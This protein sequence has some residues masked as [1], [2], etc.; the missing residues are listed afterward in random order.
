MITDKAS[1]VIAKYLADYAEP[2]ASAT[3]F[4]L[5]ESSFD[6]ALILPCYDEAVAKVKSI[7]AHNA[8]YRVL[9]I[10]VV[11]APD[12]ATP[13]AI[14]TTQELYRALASYP[15]LPGATLQL[16]DAQQ[17]KTDK[18][19]VGKVSLH[20]VPNSCHGLMLVD[21]VNVARIPA[22]Q[23]VGLA[24]KIG[25][26]LALKL[27]DQGFLINGWLGSTDAD[28]KL[29]A[30]YFDTLKSLDQKVPPFAGAVFGFNHVC[31]DN[32]LHDA[33]NLYDLSLRY[34]VDA[35]AW[36]GSPYAFA[37]IGSCLA[38]HLVAYAQVRGFPKR[39]GGEDFYLLNKLCKLKLTTSME[40]SRTATAF[41]ASKITSGILPLDKCVIALEARE[42][43]RVPFGTGPAITKILMQTHPVDDYLFYHPRIFVL[44]RVWLLTM[45]RAWP[46]V[47]KGSAVDA[48]WWRCLDDVVTIIAE[49][50]PGGDFTKLTAK[51]QQVLR[52]WGEESG[53]YEALRHCLRQS[54]G[55][56][57][58]ISQ[59][60]T[61]FDGFRTL[62]FVHY[63]RQHL[64]PSLP[65]KELL[66]LTE[67]LPDDFRN[68]VLAEFRKRLYASTK[69][70]EN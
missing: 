28:A 18:S 69:H 5:K 54:G 43:H 6:I 2:E 61:W 16:A 32:R 25:A 66:H 45:H 22:K 14:K 34:Y 46:G 36:C 41:P 56:E 15:P 70:D 13:S 21:R 10:V 23:G 30:D 8:S 47:A 17:V 27:F 33:A 48:N 3:T 58:F 29:P 57:A 37:T 35:L 39:A 50:S 11:N 19:Q 42:S 20:T 31:I 4:I 26:D 12:N 52:G 64:Y 67:M 59:L 38:F 49:D 40:P 51:E 60:H 7:L 62:K 63:I 55:S 68:T 65:A 53:W 9:F 24:R 1:R 44:L